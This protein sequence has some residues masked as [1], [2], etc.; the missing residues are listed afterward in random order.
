MSGNTKTG[1][2]NAKLLPLLL[3]PALILLALGSALMGV[4]DGMQV[5]YW[6]ATMFI[7]SMSVLPITFYLFRNFDSCGY[8]MSK[9]LGILLPG[10]LVWT[11]TYLKIYRFNRIGILIM[12]LLLAAFSYG[13]KPLRENLLKCL[14]KPNILPR[15]VIEESLFVAVLVV[16]CYF[17]GF[18]PMIN[19]QEKFMDYGFIMSMLR[20]SSLPAND[21]WM[22][23]YSINYYYFG[24]Y[25]YAM[26]IKFSGIDSGYGYNIAMC[27]SIALPFMM[28]FSI[29]TMLI[30]TAWKFGMKESRLS[31]YICG[32]L[33]GCMT[34]I[35]G[36]SHS[37]F[38]DENSIGNS[39]LTGLFTKLG[40]NVGNTDSFFYPDS[41]RYIGHNPDLYQVA[42]DGTVINSGDYTI[43]EFPFYSYLVGDLHA[44]VISM[45][46]V[47]LIMAVC[48]AMVYNSIGLKNK[49]EKLKLNSAYKNLINI[50]LITAAVLLGTAIMCNY[51]DFLIYF[52]FCSMTFLV[53]N[54][55][56]ESKFTSI[57]G[58]FIFFIVM[59]AILGVYVTSSEHVLLHALLQ[60]VILAGAY[61]GY[62][63]V[64]TALT[65]T[66]FAMAFLFSG[67]NIVAI[68]FNFNFDM[69]SNSIAAVKNRSSLFQLFI[70]WGTHVFIC[71]LF[72][73][74]T[75]IYKNVGK[76]YSGKKKKSFSVAVI[77]ETPEGYSNPVEK[78]FRQRNLADV[79]ACGMAVVGI[80]M[81]IAPELIYVRDIYTGGY[82]RA[83]TM[84]KFTFAAFII[85][86]Q[87]IAYGVIRMFWFVNKQGEYS[88]LTFCLAVVCCILLLVPAHY[89]YV[90]LKQRCGDLSH[91][92]YQTIDGT[93]YLSTYTSSYVADT[94]SGNLQ[95]YSECIDWFN[96]NVS[97]SPVICEA[98][99]LSYTDNN[100]VSA[101]TGLPTVCGWQT[102]EWLWRFHGIVNEEEDILESDPDRDVWKL[103]L[104]PRHTDIDTVYTSS[105]TNAIQDIINKYDI[106]Y[107]IIGD[108]ETNNYGYDNRYIL[109]QLGETCFT[110]G[111]LEVIRVT[112]E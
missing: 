12:V 86:S 76:V 69:I 94:E 72:I 33:S 48:V 70:L 80:L 34:M 44:H 42:S 51:W 90:S 30:E 11:L 9:A 81:L 22:S 29:G 43:H 2:K 8:I 73:V 3:I 100:I 95:S 109:E 83:N 50:P 58:T 108:L 110:S 15:L 27:C 78:F 93:E 60:L 97:G 10:L 25:L 45:M 61:V 4:S 40:I 47:L 91:E 88:S 64:P 98:Y 21:M 67:A 54:T 19:G 106:E 104:T 1:F 17:K 57:K 38:Y 46:V 101:Y 6:A 87:V 66:S 37:F 20:S 63:F 111:R 79:F 99:G 75:V 56:S 24:Q 49:A 103:Y 52:I 105:D 65:K 107:I 14:D 32:I 13:F 36:N 41:T 84:F 112:P 71:I 68:P 62:T 102:H 5:F 77:G 7:L 26:I 89:T 74:F 35:F 39:L 55:V 18:N 59:F 96:D 23:G 28:S 92:Y 53:I 85:L 16:L 82:L 31:R